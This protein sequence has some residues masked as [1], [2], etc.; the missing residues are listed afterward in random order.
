MVRCDEIG[1]GYGDGDRGDSPSSY[2]RLPL[3]LQPRPPYYFILTAPN[4][5]NTQHHNAYHAHDNSSDNSS[6]NH[7]DN[8][9]H[10]NAHAHVHDNAQRTVVSTTALSPL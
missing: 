10:D 8:N 4:P 7:L 6:D 1:D 2:A 5:L 3:P 9:A